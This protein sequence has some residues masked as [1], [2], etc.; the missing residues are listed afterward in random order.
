MYKVYNTCAF[1]SIVHILLRCVFDDN[2]YASVLKDSTN[3]VVKFIL[4]LAEV[5]PTAKIYRIRLTLLMPHYKPIKTT[6]VGNII[7]SISIDAEDCVSI[8]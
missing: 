1:D 5:G 4:L 3:K 2:Y 6:K 8:V 7:T